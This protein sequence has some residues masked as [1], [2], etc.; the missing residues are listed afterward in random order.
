MTRRIKFVTFSIISCALLHA[1]ERPPFQTDFPADELAQRRARVMDA[2]GAD[3][4]AIVQ[5]APG[6][7][8]FKVFRQTNEFYY[9]TG[10]ETPHA[11]LVLDGRTRKTTLF[12]TPRNE[13]LER[14]TGAVWSAEDAAEVISAHRR[15]CGGAGGA[16]VAPDVQRHAAAAETAALSTV[17]PRGR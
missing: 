17:Q 10:L 2:I 12:L 13:A 1:Q 5:G 7:D 3:G 14:S 16:A 4:I 8:G 9:L 15:R 11:C 6:V